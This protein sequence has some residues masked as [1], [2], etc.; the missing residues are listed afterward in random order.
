MPSTTFVARRPELFSALV[1]VAEIGGLHLE[2]QAPVRVT[3]RYYDT[4]AGDLLRRGLALRVRERGGRRTVGMRAVGGVE[5]DLPADVVMA[6]FSDGRTDRLEMLPSAF[7]SVVRRAA[8]GAPLLPLLSLRQYRTPRVARDG[9]ETVGVLSFDVVVYEAPGAREVSNEVEVELR[10]G[11][12]LARLAPE[13]EAHDLEAVARSTFERAILRHTRTLAQPVLLLPDE[14]G[15]LEHR[16]ASGATRERRRAKAVLLDARGFRPDT[17]A[18]QTGLSVGRVRHWRQRFREV[19]LGMFDPSR[20]ALARRTASLDRPSAASADGPPPAPTPPASTPM[21]RTADS[22]RRPSSA[23]PPVPPE[24][25][26][27]A[28]GG[29]GMPANGAADAVGAVDMAELLELFS[30][31]PPDT[32]LLADLPLPDLAED[33]DDDA[34]DDAFDRLDEEPGAPA[35]PVLRQ[36]PAASTPHASGARLNPYPVVLGP[37]TLER[38]SSVRASSVLEADAGV[39]AQGLAAASGGAGLA[40]GRGSPPETVGSPLG[41]SSDPFAEVDLRRLRRDRAAGPPAAS[42]EPAAE[43]RGARPVFVWSAPDGPGHPPSRPSFSGGT[44]LLEAAH[45]SLSHHLGQFEDR[46]SRFLGSRAPSDARRLL[47][48]SHGLRLTVETFGP[49]IPQHAAGRLIATLRPLVRDLGAGL[50]H[51]R[52]AT[53]APRPDETARLAAASLASAA[54]RLDSHRQHDWS[55]WT[56]RLLAHL[57]RQ[58]D[59]GLRTD[60]WAAPSPDDFVGDPGDAPTPALLRHTVG[61]ALWARFESIRAFEAD[62][63]ALTPD[64]ASHLAVAL[65]S[66][67]FVLRLAE[68][69]SGQAVA[70][71]SA[72]L[73][74]AEREVVRARDRTAGPVLSVQDA[75]AV[76]E[77]WSEITAPLFRKRL[78]RVL[79]AI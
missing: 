8:S 20:A 25:P 17:I 74:G 16:A 38:T 39:T 67:R 42:P 6:G 28:H 24:P 71:L 79:A 57:Q 10:R 44:P 18:A 37:V 36:A 52:R 64:A 77:V 54:T 26:A 7:A 47:I 58:R 78:A 63:D 46:A 34:D 33:Y 66:L 56:H 2:P 15:E 53:L 9:D 31:P 19:R 40:A 59:L 35:A 73:D 43:P 72:A 51:A 48:A 49:V 76:A 61:S 14:V 75:S 32:P 69:A 50:D 11:D 1:Q 41:R 3:D 23:R 12:L 27:R 62:L 21:E 45:Q 30:P 70:D 55:A 65:S 13:L 60:D 29:D 68:S 4:D 5:A 22:P